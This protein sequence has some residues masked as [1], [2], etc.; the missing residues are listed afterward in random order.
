MHAFQ[1]FYQNCGGLASNQQHTDF[2]K[3]LLLAQHTRRFKTCLLLYP[4]E[5][6]PHKKPREGF[7]PSPSALTVQERLLHETFSNLIT[8]SNQ[9][10]YRGKLNISL[11][12]NQFFVMRFCRFQVIEASCGHTYT[13]VG[14]TAR[15]PLEMLDNI[16]VFDTQYDYVVVYQAVISDVNPR[17]LLNYFHD[18]TPEPLTRIGCNCIL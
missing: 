4:F 13:V 7:E 3:R 2:L 8:R 14:P 6:P 10:S 12:R 5:L 18:I 17:E 9:L 1:S 11:I 15:C 16:P